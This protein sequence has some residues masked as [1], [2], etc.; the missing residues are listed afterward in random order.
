MSFISKRYSHALFEL[1]LE[2]QCLEQV[3]QDFSFLENT[4][5]TVPEFKTL[6]SQAPLNQSQFQE[7]LR[8]FSVTMAFSDITIKFLRVLGS[9]RRQNYLISIIHDFKQL[10]QTY[11]SEIKAHVTTA[12]PL[13]REQHEQ[14]IETLEKH[15][16]KRM[17]LAQA[18]DPTLLSGIVIDCEGFRID[19]SIKTQ[20]A[21]WQNEIRV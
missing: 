10:A 1:S 12:Y 21:Q 5:N 13:S 8:T 20:L 11:R 19:T 9:K 17:I 14:L 16:N 2:Y 6:I 3:I 7:F 18:V 4:L 15:L